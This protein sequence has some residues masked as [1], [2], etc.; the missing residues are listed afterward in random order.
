MKQKN[1]LTEEE[2]IK[3]VEIG[4]AFWEK[5][6]VL[7]AEHIAMMPP[8]LEALTTL[9]LQDKTSIYGTPIDENLIKVRAK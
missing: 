7:A 1:R 8:E 6:G 4:D 3:L 5:F 2:H 9:Y